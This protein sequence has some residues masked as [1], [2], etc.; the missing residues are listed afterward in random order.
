MSRASPARVVLITGAASGLGAA[1][2]LALR[3][4]GW[5]V[6]LSDQ[7]AEGL[8][9]R[10]RELSLSTAEASP[11][12]SVVT[13]VTSLAQCEAAVQATL[14][15]HGRLDAVWANAGM[16]SFGPL[17]H[18][19][20]QAWHRCIEVNVGGVFHTV[21][22]ALPALMRQRGYACIS[23]S[24]ASFAHPPLMSAYAASKAAVEA[25][26]N[27]WRIELASHGVGVGV[28]HA[29][30]IRTALVEDG[31][32]HPAFERLRCTAPAAM[33]QIMPV[34]QAA[35]LVARGIERRDPRIWVPGWVRWMHRLR[36]LLHTPWGEREL[37]RAAPQLESLYLQVLEQHG[38]QASSYAPRE[39]A[40]A[41][42][43]SQAAAPG[44]GHSGS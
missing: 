40:R 11:V 1:G 35:A 5:S 28:V 29:S 16:A 41:L 27:A 24:V 38:A 10:A 19:D 26:A 43:R 4:R 21:R 3:Q 36:A 17:S 14:E 6:V 32:Q 20:P 37:R 31:A 22:A 42:E 25:M 33:R 7:D 23:A 39:L 2:A 34:A 9:R 15:R 44:Q 13:D 18:T 30:W 12:L 8:Q